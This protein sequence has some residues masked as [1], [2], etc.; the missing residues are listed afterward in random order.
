MVAIISVNGNIGSG[1]S[2]LLQQVYLENEKRRQNDP[3]RLKIR[4]VLEPVSDWCAPVLPGDQSML[5][6][7]YE[8]MCRNA[9][10]F[11]M[12]VLLTRV[13][14]ILDILYEIESSGQDVLLVVERGPWVD[15]DLMGAPMR[16]VGSI[17]EMEWHVYEQWHAEVMRTLPAL[18]GLVYLTNP[19]EE[20]LSRVRCRKRDDERSGLCLEHLQRIHDAHASFVCDCDLPKLSIESADDQQSETARQILDWIEKSGM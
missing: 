12:H 18:S 19:P 13:R 20:C 5:G 14:Q 7:F 15:I 17:T 4:V 3:D 9:F 1:K 6:A 11:Q 10:P 8:D 2:T 16:D